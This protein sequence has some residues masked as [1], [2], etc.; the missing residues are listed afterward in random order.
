MTAPQKRSARSVSPLSRRQFLVGAGASLGAAG[1]AA[2][3]AHSPGL[4]QEQTG[5]GPATPNVLSSTPVPPE[6]TEYS[7]DWPVAQGNLAATRAAE[8]SPINGQ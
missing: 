4:A 1:L 7:G 5:T 6:V 2:I 8:N 3:V